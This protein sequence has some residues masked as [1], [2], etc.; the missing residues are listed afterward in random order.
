VAEN[1]SKALLGFAKQARFAPAAFL[2][3]F[4]VWGGQYA[5]RFEEGLLRT[6][7]SFVCLFALVIGVAVIADAAVKAVQAD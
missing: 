5:A 3:A 2:A 7:A 4:G 1:L 6:A